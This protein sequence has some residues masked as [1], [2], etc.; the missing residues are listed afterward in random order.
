MPN[1]RGSPDCHICKFVVS[2]EDRKECSKHKFVIPRISSEKLCCDWQHNETHTRRPFPKLLPGVLY[3]YSYAS[4]QKPEPLDTFEHFNKSIEY[5]FVSLCDDLEYGWSLYLRQTDYKYFPTPGGKVTLQLNN[6]ESEFEIVDATRIHSQGCTRQEDGSLKKRWSRGN[7]R[8]I[9]CPLDPFIL[10]TWLDSFFNVER[11]LFH[12]R[13][14]LREYLSAF[15]IHI[16]FEAVP[17]ENV[18]RIKPD[19]HM[20]GEFGRGP[21]KRGK[22]SMQ[23]LFFKSILS[24]LR[25]RERRKYVAIGLK[26]WYHW[27]II[28]LKTYYKDILKRS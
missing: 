25:S 13:K 19:I 7:Q 14:A 21:Y 16:L 4:I 22:P 24:T 20:Y 1:G 15:R 28:K 12:Y 11:I 10:Y 6:T 27:N 3:Y 9:Y 18:L 26:Q 2:N 5:F 8:I 23:Y 17:T